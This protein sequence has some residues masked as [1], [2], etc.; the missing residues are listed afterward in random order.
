MLI[1]RRIKA[2]EK[3]TGG[4]E[5]A[6][7]DVCKMLLPSTLSVGCVAALIVV[8]IKLSAR[9][10]AERLQNVNPPKKLYVYPFVSLIVFEKSAQDVNSS[11]LF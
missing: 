7:A 9:F 5:L 1:Y 8:S 11:C 10:I 6:W 2:I 3:K 4:I